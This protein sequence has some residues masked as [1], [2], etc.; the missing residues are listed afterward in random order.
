MPTNL[1]VLKRNLDIVR[2]QSPEDLQV[3]RVL[4]QLHISQQALED[5]AIPFDN[6]SVSI[7]A[8]NDDQATMYS[9]NEEYT[10]RQWRYQV[11]SD[12]NFLR[13]R[14][15]QAESPTASAELQKVNEAHVGLADLI[16]WV[17]EEDADPT[18]VMAFQETDRG[19]KALTEATRAAY[20][21]FGPSN[22]RETRAAIE[23]H[24]GEELA[25]SYVDYLDNQFPKQTS[26]SEAPMLT[27]RDV[28]RLGKELWSAFR[29]ETNTPENRIG[30]TLAAGRQENQWQ[31]EDRF[32]KADYWRSAIDTAF[33]QALPSYSQWT[34]TTQLQDRLTPAQA[35]KSI[36]RNARTARK[37][38]NPVDP[39]VTYL[40][41]GVDNSV[42]SDLGRDGVNHIVVFG[43]KQGDPLVATNLYP[44]L[45]DYALLTAPDKNC[46][47]VHLKSSDAQARLQVL[48]SV[49]QE[50]KPKLTP[51]R[52]DWI[53]REIEKTFQ[54]WRDLP[55]TDRHDLKAGI[56][57]VHERIHQLAR[58]LPAPG[59]RGGASGRDSVRRLVELALLSG[60]PRNDGRPLE[61]RLPDELETGPFG[62]CPAA[63]VTRVDNGDGTYDIHWQGLDDHGNTKDEPYR[64][65][66]SVPMSDMNA[67][68]RRVSSEAGEI[69]GLRAPTIPG[70]VVHDFTPEGNAVTTG[71]YVSEQ[72][73][74]ASVT[75]S[76]YTLL[77]RDSTGTPLFDWKDNRYRSGADAREMQEVAVE[78]MHGGTLSGEQTLQAIEVASFDG[79]FLLDLNQAEEDLVGTPQF[80]LNPELFR[81]A[82]RD[83]LKT[84]LCQ[85]IACS[86][87][88]STRAGAM[89]QNVQNGSW[90]DAKRSLDEMLGPYSEEPESPGIRF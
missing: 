26:L 57:D 32:L 45:L 50:L 88:E 52:L 29:Y 35:M 79:D 12:L 56:K 63:E 46:K 69:I 36:K 58:E 78:M 9:V 41:D 23:R 72:E 85:H 17:C 59:V 90:I 70:L 77:Y 44:G 81:V 40:E 65:A 28:L 37:Q 10:A 61:F 55:L 19:R 30:A 1:A 39:V 33:E 18:Q 53:D 60:M 25:Q 13:E 27:E 74:K 22:M 7:P 31:I 73:R 11:L 75:H 15:S 6:H 8:K 20:D 4:S 47:A 66:R 67:Y 68:I 43:D 62:L 42:L 76:P 89:I 5:A 16:E 80:N 2:S 71:H 51:Q 64:V 54:M 48:Q 82:S 3:P 24:L 14:A 38:F 84:A 21:K 83:D 49:A 34:A 87:L 86:T